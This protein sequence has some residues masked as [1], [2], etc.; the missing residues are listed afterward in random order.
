MNWD[1]I[2]GNWKQ[3]KG[4]AQ[5]RWGELSGDELDQAEGSREQ[6][7]GLIQA[8]YGKTKEEARQEVDQWVAEH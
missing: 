7:E 2:Q 5:E 6:L 8:R 3:M 4:R 1:Q